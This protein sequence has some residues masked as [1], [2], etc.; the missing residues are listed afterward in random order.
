VF[1][2]VVNDVGLWGRGYTASLGTKF[3]GAETSFRAWAEG[4][5]LVPYRLGE[6]LCVTVESKV[7]IAHLCAQRG[8]GTSKRRI[9]Y[10]ALDQCL[11]WL[12]DTKQV[13]RTVVIPKIGTGLAGGEWEDISEII[14][15]R[16]RD[17]SVVVYE[18]E[19]RNA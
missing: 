8:V 16:L 7:N 10:Q 3:P 2:H 11:W 12:A 4:G 17:Y 13:D 5:F 18:L 14:E 15:R 1:A 6:V 19:P 9:D